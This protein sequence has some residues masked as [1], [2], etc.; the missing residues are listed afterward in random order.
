MGT[1]RSG[2]ATVSCLG[3]CNYMNEAHTL[4]SWVDTKSARSYVDEACLALLQRCLDGDEAAFVTL[5]DQHAAMVYRLAYSLLLNKEDAEEV[6]QDSFEYAFRK[7][8]HYNPQKSAF[9]TWLYRITV[10]RC[11]N[12]RRRKWLPT[13]SL[14]LLPQQDVPDQ[15][16]PTPDSLLE[17]DEQQ[18]I[19]WDALGQL[20]SKLRETAILRYYHGLRYNEIGEILAIP[21]KTAESRIRLAHKA[22]RN[23]LDDDK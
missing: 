4:S 19:I 18:K 7:L 6:L 22:L 14:S 2:T 20:S 16:S 8:A 5:Y 23:Y 3:S 13:F 12:K 21:P 1:R 11:R 9:K 10:S 17:L 15:Y